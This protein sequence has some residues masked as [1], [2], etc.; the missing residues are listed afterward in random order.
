MAPVDARRFLVPPASNLGQ[1]DDDPR[2][3]HAA[4]REGVRGLSHGHEIRPGLAPK[5]CYPTVTA[6]QFDQNHDRP[7]GAGTGF[8]PTGG[9][10]RQPGPRPTR[11]T[12]QVAGR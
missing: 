11:S 2:S 7:G 4:P 10:H 8:S 1:R 3:P 12:S 9:Q 6:C 5:K